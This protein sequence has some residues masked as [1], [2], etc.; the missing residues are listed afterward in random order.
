MVSTLLREI[1]KDL[2]ILPN[3]FVICH[4]FMGTGLREQAI[5]QEHRIHKNIQLQR[6]CSLWRFSFHPVFEISED[7]FGLLPNKA[8]KYI[9]L[10]RA[11]KVV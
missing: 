8:E 4:N 2:Q 5:L 7:F 9:A 3:F 10:F 1:F 11:W 6:T